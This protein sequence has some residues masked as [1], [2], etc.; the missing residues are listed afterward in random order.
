MNGTGGVRQSPA[1]LAQLSDVMFRPHWQSTVALGL[2][3]P[4]PCTASLCNRLCL[5]MQCRAQAMLREAG[6]G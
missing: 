2:V 1:S 6:L 4:W 5:A 3:L